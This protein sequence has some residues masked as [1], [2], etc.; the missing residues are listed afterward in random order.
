[1]PKN[2]LKDLVDDP[3]SHLRNKERAD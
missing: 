1:M 3:F 2:K